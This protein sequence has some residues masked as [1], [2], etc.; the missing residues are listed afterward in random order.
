MACGSVRVLGVD[1]SLT[2][3]GLALV[4]SGR[5]ERVWS[6]RPKMR[7]NERLRLIVSSVLEAAQGVDVV[8][9]EGPSMHSQ[10][11]SLVQLYGLFTLLT[12]SLWVAGVRTVVV[13]P[14]VRAMY[15]TGRGNANKDAV[16]LSVARRYPNVDVQDN[17]QADAL[18]MA[19]LVCRALGEPVAGETVPQAALRA[20]DRLEV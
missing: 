1:Q 13:P 5:V 19:A 16:L 2:C 6:L 4:C 3:S 14:T 18:A 8:V 7:G 17:N 11:R 10:G 12:Y 9:V 15:A 20:V